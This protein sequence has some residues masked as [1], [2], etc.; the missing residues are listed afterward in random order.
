MAQ[1][2]LLGLGGT[3]SRIVNNV[4]AELRKNHLSVDDGNICCA[5]IDTD[6]NDQ[7]RLAGSDTGIPI[8]STSRD[9]V[10]ERYMHSYA[11]SGIY[12][13]MPEAPLWSIHSM[14]SGAGQMRYL[15]RLA[16]MD[17]IANEDIR[18]LENHINKLFNHRDN[19]T[20]RVMIV[21]SLAGGTGSG[22]FIQMALW[23]RRYFA[24][25]NEDEVIIK[26]IFVLP[27]VFVRTIDEFRDQKKQR[28]IYANAYGAVRELNAI[29]KIK[30]N[31]L[32]MSRRIQLDGLF[33]SDRDRGD[34]KP[35]Y[36]FAFFVDDISEAGA[37]LGDLAEYEKVVARLVY[38]QLYAPMADR[39]SSM[40]DN[41]LKLLQGSNEPVFGT[42]G[43]AKAVY[44]MESV[45]RYCA[46]RASQD[47]IS[48]GWRRIDEEIEQKE[49][50]QKERERN[51]I[52]SDAPL[53]KR[54]E[55]IRLFDELSTKT[56]D[57]LG[58]D[59]LF[60][61]IGKDIYYQIRSRGENDSINVEYVD[62]GAWFISRIEELVRGVPIAGLDELK[63]PRDW[64]KNESG[65]RK[66]LIDF[67]TRKENEVTQFIIGVEKTA[68]AR[69]ESLLSGIF[70]TNMGD[71]NK[72][73]EDS[74]FGFLTKEDSNG[75][76]VFVHPLAVRYLLYKLKALV[77]E[78]KGKI[79]PE[80][81]KQDAAEGPSTLRFDYRRSK[82]NEATYKDYLRVEPAK[83]HEAE[84]VREFKAI[85]E[86]FNRA[87]CENC[88]EF[89]IDS[90]K[91]HLLRM[92]SKRIEVMIKLVDNFFKNL[93]KVNNTIN[94]ALDANVRDI[95]DM[96][97]KIMYICAS[98]R[99]KE[100]MYGSLDLDLEGSDNDINA[101]V[102]SALYGL[103]CATE[104]PN[105]ENN[106]PYKGKSVE[107]AFYRNIVRTYHALIAATKSEDIDLDIYT[108][109]CRSV[110]FAAKKKSGAESE[111]EDDS[112]ILHVDL[113]TDEEVSDS[114][115]AQARYLDRFTA[116]T[117]RLYQLSSPMLITEEATPPG[118]EEIKKRTD[119][120][121]GG[122]AFDGT[123]SESTLWGFHPVVA[124]KCRELGRILRVNA[125]SEQDEDYAKN[126][127]ECCRVIYGVQACYIP[128][129]NEMKGGVYYSS[130][131][132]VVDEMIRAAGTGDTTALVNTP[133][134]DKTWHEVL[135]YITPEKQ[136][137]ETRGFLRSFWLA[138]AYGMVYIDDDVYQ[139]KRTKQTVMG[140]Y[141]V[142]EPVRHDGDPI[143]KTDVPKLI[144]ALRQDPIF[145]QDA[146][147]LEEKF[148]AE[149]EQVASYEGTEFFRGRVGAVTRSAAD[150]GSAETA[151]EGGTTYKGGIA[152]TK[153][154]NGVTLIVRHHNSPRHDPEETILLVQSLEALL[155]DLVSSKYPHDEEGKVKAKARELGRRVYDASAMKNK[156][157]EFLL[158]WIEG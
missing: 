157:I 101:I 21:S 77:D 42:S 64:T 113:D 13:W 58:S 1:T 103:F 76:R 45:L 80:G 143:G 102:V 125:E 142:A 20:I 26:G 14:R 69:A 71:V 23:L 106:R 96:E 117:D 95:S 35:V 122:R 146:A 52:Y 37:N 6:G 128:K 148:A 9:R 11:E 145:M 5:V 137:I 123:K 53:D 65:G 152:T 36:D 107:T 56:G 144:E 54:A 139:I 50:K 126:E 33:D 79:L 133:H 73:N 62:K 91:L 34:G 12:S 89:A 49:E 55:F 61:S 110:D 119:V 18:K 31:G 153:D 134:M 40:E 7:E 156:N 129:F 109:I 141:T 60:R 63:L 158:G 94:A 39:M 16:L 105:A 74:V 30:G 46:L 47:A 100:A 28:S 88:R 87:Q 66:R 127:L 27:D 44:P 154:T 90:I 97:Q 121:Q 8:I 115:D 93:D 140:S 83:K 10:V 51:G 22:M 67:I 92:L 82:A 131:R 48:K 112:D 86:R 70:T 24:G 29:T 85:Y 114:G 59:R 25:R 4:A 15:S 136:E 149:R 116:V 84:Y 118:L 17:T 2:L 19:N 124:S 43:G 72:A 57:K 111:W 32:H 108:A 130:Y 132:T 3:G 138:V 104:N 81:S 99:E 155:G 120:D 150:D 98:R 135:P 41:L 78:E 151:E 38:A 147:A 75:D 68:E